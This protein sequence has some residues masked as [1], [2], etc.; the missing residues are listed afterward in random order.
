MF[1]FYQGIKFYIYSNDHNPPHFHAIFAEYEVVIEILT[2]EIMAGE[3]PN[4]KLK[5]ILKRAKLSQ[6][7]MLIEFEA[8]N[9]G[10]RK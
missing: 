9:P 4:N 7:E 5:A 10:L 6:A 1:D 8:L 3:M 2:L